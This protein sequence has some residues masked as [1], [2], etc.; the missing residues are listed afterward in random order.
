LLKAQSA[1]AVGFE[2]AQRQQEKPPVDQQEQEQ[3]EGSEAQGEPCPE[4]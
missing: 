3:E 2:E 1:V 4:G